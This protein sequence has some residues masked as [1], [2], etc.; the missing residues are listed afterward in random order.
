MVLCVPADTLT[1]DFYPLGWWE[2]TFL[3]FE[4]T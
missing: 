2:N 3:L 1:S 4:D